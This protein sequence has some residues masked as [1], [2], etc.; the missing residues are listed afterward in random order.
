[1]A[2][3]GWLFIGSCSALSAG[4]R[5]QQL[6][7]RPD[8]ARRR[9]LHRDGVRLEQPHQG[10]AALHLEPGRGQR[11][12]HGR[13][14][15]RRSSA[16]C[17]ASRPSP[18]PGRRCC[19]R[20]VLYIVVP[21]ILAQIAPHR[22]CSVAARRPRKVARPFQPLS[23]VAL[24]ATLVLLFGFQGSR[25][26]PSRSSSPC[27]RCRSSSRSISIPGLPIFSTAPR[28][29]A[30]RRRPL[31][32]D[33]R[34]Q[35]LRAGSRRRDQPVRLQ[36]RRG[37]RDRRRRADR[38][39]GDAVGREDRERQQGLVRKRRGGRQACAACGRRPGAIG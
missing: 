5:D 18:C 20:S 32:A 21:V 39:A 36:F 14:R 4:R 30:L 26:S 16:C 29:G 25:S 7:R 10:R 31:G 37:A 23:I 17:W 8:P 13:S 34:Q 15:S 24:L 9:A 1:M 3:L 6:H 27:W 38:G 28:R 2:F 22:C 12:H 33:R 11:R 35:L 19:C